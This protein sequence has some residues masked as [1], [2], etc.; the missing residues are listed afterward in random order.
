[1]DATTLYMVITLSDGTTRRAREQVFPS[2]A[3]CEAFA[4]EAAKRIPEGAT[5]VS[6]EC[7]RHYRIAPGR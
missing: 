4:A 7:H 2:V 1:M 6:A 3:A 5:I